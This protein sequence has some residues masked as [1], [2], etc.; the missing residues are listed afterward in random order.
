MSKSQVPEN[1]THS[2]HPTS[3]LLCDALLRIVAIKH[4]NQYTWK[5]LNIRKFMQMKVPVGKYML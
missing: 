2:K 4:D 1:I 5:Y 3:L